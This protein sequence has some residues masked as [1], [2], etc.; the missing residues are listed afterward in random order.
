MSIFL[1]VLFRPVSAVG[2]HARK[3]CVALAA[4]ILLASSNLNASVSHGLDSNSRIEVKA[5]H[6]TGKVANVLI[7]TWADRGDENFGRP[8]STYYYLVQFSADGSASAPRPAA[9]NICASPLTPGRAA[10]Q[11]RCC[12]ADR[13]RNAVLAQ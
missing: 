7:A 4:L 13:G 2:P 5:I 1:S 6:V 8:C 3:A 12:A 11:R 9:S 10:G